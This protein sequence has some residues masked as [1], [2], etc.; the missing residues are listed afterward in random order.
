MV[1]VIISSI[2]SGFE[3]IILKLIELGPVMLQLLFGFIVAFFAIKFIQ[4]LIRRV[5]ERVD[6]NPDIEQLITNFA[7]YILWFFVLVWGVGSLGL[8]EVFQSILALGAL[9]GLAVSLAAKDS[10][11]DV[12]AGIMILKDRHFDVGDKVKASGKEG[13][14]IEV[15]LRKTRLQ[16]DDGSISIIPN[17]KIDNGGWELVE[18]NGQKGKAFAEKKEFSDYVNTGKKRIK[19]ITGLK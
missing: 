9:G 7:G 1:E 6:L 10:L 3:Q 12:V 15:S 16:L 19:R 17:A 11:A 2:L 13:I 18:R 14:I 8:E 4:Y 5:F